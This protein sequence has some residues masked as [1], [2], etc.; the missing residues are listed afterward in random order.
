MMHLRGGNSDLLDGQL[1]YVTTIGDRITFK[2]SGSAMV[3]NDFLV[4]NQSATS[5]LI[6]PN[7]NAASSSL[8]YDAVSHYGDIGNTFTAAGGA[9]AGRTVFLPCYT[10]GELVA[11]DK[12]PFSQN[13]SQ[14]RGVTH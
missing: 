9:L 5:T 3:A 13:Y 7:N 6:E 14:L 1:R 11:G 2:I 10:E 12:K 4:D 8:D